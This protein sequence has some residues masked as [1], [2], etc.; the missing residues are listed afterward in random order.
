[1]TQQV[2]RVA[3]V[4]AGE[5]DVVVGIDDLDGE[6]VARGPE[7][8]QLPVHGHS[9]TDQ[10]LVAEDVAQREGHVGGRERVLVP[11]IERAEL[12]AEQADP[13]PRVRGQRHPLHVGLLEVDAD[14]VVVL[15]RRPASRCGRSLQLGRLLM[16]R[17]VALE[18]RVGV[19]RRLE[20]DLRSAQQELVADLTVGPV[21]GNI[22]EE[23]DL[24]IERLEVALTSRHG[25]TLLLGFPLLLGLVRRGFL[26]LG[27]QLVELLFS[28]AFP[29][30]R[31]QPLQLGDAGL[32]RLDLLPALLVQTLEQLLQTRQL[33]S[34]RLFG[35]FFDR[36]GNGSGG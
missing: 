4:R 25:V 12:L 21:V 3:K 13:Q 20:R 15:L 1:M 30:L 11:A 9:E 10:A 5:R 22:A 36:L 24:G 27:D 31:E 23:A 32:Q 29:G 6:R 2:G 34:Q 35:A 17:Q 7:T 14:L 16:R 26:G 28:L 18:T 8:R 19:Q 33:I